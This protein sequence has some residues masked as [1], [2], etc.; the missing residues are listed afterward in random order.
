MICSSPEVVE[1][2]A[3]TPEMVE[4]PPPPPREGSKEKTRALASHQ[5]VSIYVL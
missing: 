1:V 3:P 5:G 4:V 2:P